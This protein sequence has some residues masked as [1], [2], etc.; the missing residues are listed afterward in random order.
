MQRTFSEQYT[1][2]PVKCRLHNHC[3]VDILTPALLWWHLSSLIVSECTHLLKKADC[4]K[5]GMRMLSLFAMLLT[6][7]SVSK[8]PSSNIAYMS[9]LPYLLLFCSFSST[10]RLQTRTSMRRWTCSRRG[11]REPWILN[12]IKTV[13][14]KYIS[15]WM[16]DENLRWKWVQLTGISSAA[17][18]EPFYLLIGIFSNYKSS[19]SVNISINMFCKRH[20]MSLLNRN[21]W[22]TLYNKYIE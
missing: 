21:W 11:R 6:A 4:H 18:L 13:R 19:I 15:K 8:A 14:V 1:E 22:Q 3:K 16:M 2:H 7:L 20:Q 5:I 10:R 9:A 17:S 12:K